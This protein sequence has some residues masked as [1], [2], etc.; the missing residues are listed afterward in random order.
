M[1]DE[2]AS[3]M[4]PSTPEQVA[5]EAEVMLLR[6]MTRTF[7]TFTAEMVAHRGDMGQLKTD[8]AVIKERQ[9]QNAEMR[10]TMDEMRREIDLLKAR[11]SQQDGAYTFLTML[12]DF[13]PWLFALFVFYWGLFERK[14]G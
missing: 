12:K 5:R 11:N 13:G 8:I 7:E 6:Q 2:R 14:P 4:T 10:E 9:M 1:S 3:F